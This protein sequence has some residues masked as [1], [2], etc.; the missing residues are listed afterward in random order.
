MEYIYSN[1]ISGFEAI[2]DKL[3]QI[4]LFAAVRPATAKLPARFPNLTQSLPRLDR[5]IAQGNAPGYANGDRA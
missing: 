1:A 5:A 2:F 4:T 3:R